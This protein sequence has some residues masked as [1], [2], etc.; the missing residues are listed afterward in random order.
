MTTL[1]GSVGSSGWPPQ[2]ADG[3]IPAEAAEVP[4]QELT[5][6]GPSKVSSSFLSGV[7]EK[8]VKAGKE[9]NSP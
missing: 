5:L 9:R 3:R 1:P 2:A 6:S 7:L 8:A 4:P